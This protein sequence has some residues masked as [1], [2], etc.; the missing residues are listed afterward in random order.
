MHGRYGLSLLRLG[1]GPV[2]MTDATGEIRQAAQFL[3]P[4][5]VLR[6]GRTHFTREAA[7]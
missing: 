2:E 3:V 5:G 7:V 4:H 1:E 6:A